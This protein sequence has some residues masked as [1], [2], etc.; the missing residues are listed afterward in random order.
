MIDKKI[1]KLCENAEKCG[2]MRGNEIY[3]CDYVIICGKMRES[4]DY[5]IYQF[6][7]KCASILV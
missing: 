5:I 2:E 6:E 1:R 4:V 7:K 3:K